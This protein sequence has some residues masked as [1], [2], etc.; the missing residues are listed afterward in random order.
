MRPTRRFV[1]IACLLAIVCL[2]SWLGWNLFLRRPDA[3][4]PWFTDAGAEVGLRF[5]HDAGPPGYD[6]P[7]IMGSGAALFDAD[8]DGRLDAYLLQNGGP[9]GARNQ[10]YRQRPDGTFEDVSAGSGLDF[11]GNCMGVAIGDVNNDGWSDVLVT[12]H[13]GARLFLNRGG[14]KFT[15]VTA[16]AG[17]ANAGW[18]SSAAFFDYD[19]DGWLDLLIVN[20]L[21]YDPAVRCTAYDGKSDYCPPPRFPSQAA[22]LYHNLGSELAAAA[23]TV[24]TTRFRDVTDAAGLSKAPAP[25]LGVVCA[26]FDGDGWPDIFIANDGQANHLW[27]NRRDGTFR[28][29]A[30]ARGIAYH[31]YGGPTAGMG[32][33]VADVNGDGLLDVFVTHLTDET[34]TLWEQGPRG[35]FTDRTAVSNLAQPSRRG[36]GF[37]TAVADFDL[38]G[39]AD[40]AVVCGRVARGRVTG[41]P[42]L[43]P[44]WGAYAEPNQLFANDGTGRFRDISAGNSAFCQPPAISRGLAFGD[45]D[46]DGAID[47]L[48]TAV[49]GP[50]RMFRNIAPRRGNWII[51]RAFDSRLR[52]DAIGAEIRVHAGAKTWLGLV[53]PAGSYLCSSDVRT[54]FGLGA[55]DRI[56]RIEVQWP[57]G[58]G[59]VFDGDGGNG[60]P[61]NRVLTL[62]YGTGQPRKETKR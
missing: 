53:N 25:G 26:D 7:Q 19:R 57:N 11:A 56:D 15:E 33:G 35:W 54:H 4:A 58:I 37:G 41:Y 12:E 2:V 62:E 18:G 5:T 17:L 43:G 13:R 3:E 51:I 24:P 46:G 48:V 31:G 59:E 50:A 30:V 36:T 39:A 61:T 21:E 49:A 27:L 23:P 52:R 44:H 28:E 55:V 47:M 42:D 38:D 16:A 29:E 1:R 40:V 60:Y 34:H 6:M 14:W 45:V 20:Y 32:V 9:A 10:L 8:N 22:R